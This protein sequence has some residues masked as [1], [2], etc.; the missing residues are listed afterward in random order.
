MVG[1]RLEGLD[2]PCFKELRPGGG[3]EL[4]SSVRGDCLG[5]A[6]LADPSLG[7]G[8]DD[9]LGGDVLQ[10]YRCWPPCEAVD[11]RQQVFV[12]VGRRHGNQIGVEVG[13]TPVWH[14]KVADGRSRVS[15]HFSSLALE[16][17][18]GPLGAVG[19]DRWPHELVGD[20]LLGPV[21]TGMAE[22]VDG[23]EYLSAPIERHERTR[24]TV[25][26]VHE[27]LRLTDVHPPEA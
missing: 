6:V 23:V 2:A 18:L 20:H 17:L 25:R 24:E 12:T 22:P 19:A 16:T 5:D 3:S 10:R 1:R 21:D 9:S 4:R 13:E 26:D 14:L 15:G 7:E 27:K 11:D 8:V